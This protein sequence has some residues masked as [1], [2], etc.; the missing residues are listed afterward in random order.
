MV[1]ATVFRILAHSEH[2]CIVTPASSYL[3]TAFIFISIFS[4]TL[5]QSLTLTAPHSFSDAEIMGA[6]H[7]VWLTFLTAQVLLS[8]Q[9]LLVWGCL[10]LLSY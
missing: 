10:F 7:L 3:P 2:V 1:Y 9:L 8:A 6:S 5:R 4:I